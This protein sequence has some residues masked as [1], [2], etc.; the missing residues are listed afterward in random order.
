MGKILR[1]SAALV[2]LVM[3]S[4]TASLVHAE[5]LTVGPLPTGT[6]IIRPD[7][8]SVTLQ[9]PRFLITRQHLDTINATLEVNK[10]LQTNLAKT[11]EVAKNVKPEPGW[12]VASRWA[13]VG[14]AF[15]LGT[16][17]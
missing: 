2:V 11:I 6:K 15:A 10:Q 14:I 7:G 12:V 4:V 13:L 3:F 8:K 17:L 5:D 9:T 16:Q 1:K